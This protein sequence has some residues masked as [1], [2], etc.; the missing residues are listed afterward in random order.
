MPKVWQATN[1][2]ILEELNQEMFEAKKRQPQSLLW[3][4]I[5]VWFFK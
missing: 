2:P 4:A 5:V 1:L 3:V